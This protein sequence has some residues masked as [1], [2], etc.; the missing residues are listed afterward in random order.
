VWGPAQVSSTSSACGQLTLPHAPSSSPPH[1]APHLPG[2]QRLQALRQ[3]R[4]QHNHCLHTAQQRVRVRQRRK[5]PAAAT[6]LRRRA[7]GLS[8][9]PIPPAGVC[10]VQPWQP[11]PQL[12]D[13]VDAAGHRVSLRCVAEAIECRLI[14]TR[15]AERLQRPQRPLQQRLQPAGADLLAVGRG[16]AWRWGRTAGSTWRGWQCSCG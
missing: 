3:A 10:A 1:A 5:A 2:R 16:A 11:G 14:R 4:E 12:A 15:V 6:A 8:R 9:R 13:V 7:A